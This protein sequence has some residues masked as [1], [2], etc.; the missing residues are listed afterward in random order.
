MIFVLVSCVSPV[1]AHATSMVQ[2]DVAEQAQ[3]STAMVDATVGRST[4]VDGE[5]F[6]YQDTQLTLSDVLVG[7]APRQLTVRQ[8]AGTIDGRTIRVPGDAEL[9]EGERIVAFVRKVGDRWYFTVLGQSV[10]YADASGRLTPAIDSAHLFERGRDGSIGPST[11]SPQW[12]AHIDDLE[13][14]VKRLP[15]G[16]AL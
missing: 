11:Q 8:V 2:M 7:D 12:Y 5:R 6:V 1:M 14:A 15:V 4:Q 16:G 10:W 13:H 9:E 3:E